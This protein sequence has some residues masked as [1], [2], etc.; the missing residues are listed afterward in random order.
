MRDTETLKFIV[1]NEIYKSS[2]KY[3]TKFII[4]IP[5]ALQNFKEYF[6]EYKDYF[7][8]FPAN[9]LFIFQNHPF[10]NESEVSCFVRLVDSCMYS[11]NSNI[12]IYPIYDYSYPLKEYDNF[13]KRITYYFTMRKPGSIYDYLQE[14]V[15]PEK[16]Y[17]ELEEQY[18]LFNE[19]IKNITREDVK[20]KR[21]VWTYGKH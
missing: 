8:A 1:D 6:D 21:K 11:L 20:K 4:D 16:L 3:P 12:E 14:R 9:S 18:P 17:K 19:Q 13:I 2:T 5:E 15:Y 7:N 10:P